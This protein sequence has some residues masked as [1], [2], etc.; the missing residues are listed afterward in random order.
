[1]LLSL[2]DDAVRAQ[3]LMARTFAMAAIF[4]ASLAILLASIGVYGVTAFLVSQ[5]EKEVGIHMA[6]G[7]SRSKV[8]RL[9]L[10]QGMRPVLFGGALGLVGALSLSGF[11]KALLYFPGSVDVLYGARWFDPAT[12]AVLSCL[13]G[14]IA[15]FACYI[16]ARRVTRFD[17]IVALRYE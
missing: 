11:M 15:L 17:P 6:L 10:S 14:A 16:P 8:L 5:R 7:A 2:E 1:L 4:L 12:F 3:L 13:L 9:M